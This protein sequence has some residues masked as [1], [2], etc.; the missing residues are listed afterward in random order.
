MA[1]E[2]RLDV[3][4]ILQNDCY[5]DLNEM[6]GAASTQMVLHD[7]DPAHPLTPGEQE[8]LFDEITAP[9]PAASIW[10]NPP[11][12]ITR[13]LNDDKPA[14]RRSDR[15]FITLTP[16][17]QALFISIPPDPALTYDFII[18]GNESSD[19]NP[20]IIRA[21]SV[22]DQ[23]A[24]IELLS[25]LLL[26]TVAIKGAAP[27]IAVREDN[28]HWIV[29]NGF[30]VQDDYDDSDLKQRDRIK[31]ILIRNPLGR[32][33]YRT[34]TCGSLP[35]DELEEITGHQCDLNPYVQDVV[36]YETWV[37]EYMFADWAETFVAIIDKSEAV[38]SDI[39]DE[40]RHLEPEPMAEKSLGL[41]ATELPGDSTS[42]SLIYNVV[43]RISGITGQKDDPKRSITPEEAR[44]RARAAI[45]DFN[46]SQ[47]NE[48]VT[49]QNILSP[50]KV[51]R[52]DRID[53]DY[54]LVP[55]GV[56]TRI[57]AFI[58][59]S[60]SG[61]FN[62][63]SVW[64]A[65]HYVAPFELHPDFRNLTNGQE[66]SLKG[67]KIRLTAG[68]RPSSKTSQTPGVSMA[69]STLLT[70]TGV[71]L[72]G[73][74][75]YVWRPSPSSF[76][77]SR[78]FLN[79]KIN[80]L[81]RA[82]PISFYL[83]VDD[84]CLPVDDT[85]AITLPTPNYLELLADCIKQKAGNMAGEVLVLIN[86]RGNTAMVMYQSNQIMPV[87]DEL[88]EMTKIICQCLTAHP[89]GVTHFRFKGYAGDDFLTKRR[90]GGEDYPLLAAPASGGG[91]DGIPVSGCS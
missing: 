89:S 80:V 22:L 90:G 63:A 32:Y 9:P 25:R 76:S 60:A 18:L 79:L 17:L 91:G 54:Y 55:V 53:G 1:K 34:I 36:A 65:G 72:D 71:S 84:Y 50:V 85:G 56:R 46:L 77:M 13:V 74:A 14:V 6:C 31:A 40:L 30:Q 64:P 42:Y 57:F 23:I 62:E 81:E 26:R 69:K 15:G 3:P 41:N 61:E 67:R 29:V 10:Y 27:I 49:P 47:L 11:K 7:I 12:G 88:E 21:I 24:Q 4:Q 2:Y 28:A 68:D 83:P 16:A 87:E 39:L 70:I 48:I 5:S 66:T 86:R 44:D 58:N 82:A 35:E 43:V 19:D 45:A 73:T 20:G 38:A 33:T 52:L 75:P 37:R 59:I 78:P 51:K 8:T